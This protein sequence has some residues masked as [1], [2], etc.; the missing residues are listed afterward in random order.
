MKI[1]VTGVG[2]SAEDA[3]VAAISSPELKSFIEKARKI[4]FN[5]TSNS[6]LTLHEINSAAQIIYDKSNPN[7]EIIFGAAIDKELN[8]DVEISIIATDTA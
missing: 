6:N 7:A 8:I 5:F 1:K 2:K 4:T 3:A